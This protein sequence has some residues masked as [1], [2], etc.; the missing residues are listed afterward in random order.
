MP[1]KIS[2]FKVT[3]NIDNTTYIPIITG[4][5]PINKKISANKFIEP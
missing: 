2:Q 3:D 4:I 1:K 5:H